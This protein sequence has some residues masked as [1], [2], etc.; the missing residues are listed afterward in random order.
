MIVHSNYGCIISEIKRDIGQKSSFF[1]K[2]LLLTPPLGGPRGNSAMMF[3]TE[4]TRMAWLPDGEKKF[5]DAFI[6]FDVA[7]ERD[8]QTDT[9]TDT[10]TPHDG[11]GRAYAWHRAATIVFVRSAYLQII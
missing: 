9:R 3:G 8:G 1:H 6:R 11:I 10:Q 2:P 4:K 5:E 7:N